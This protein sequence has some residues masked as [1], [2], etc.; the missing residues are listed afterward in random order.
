V[1]CAYL[2]GT[3]ARLLTDAGLHHLDLTIVK[4]L[5]AIAALGLLAWGSWKLLGLVRFRTFERMEGLILRRMQ[6][7]HVDEGDTFFTDTEYL[8]RFRRRPC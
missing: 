7:S 1:G 5:L 6:P 4:G 2:F 8:G 3:I